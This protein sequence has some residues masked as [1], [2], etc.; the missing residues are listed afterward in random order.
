[1]AIPRMWGRSSRVWMPD[2]TFRNLSRLAAV[3]VLLFG[4]CAACDPPPLPWPGDGPAPS[5]WNA[6]VAVAY[7]DLPL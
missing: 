3:A 2:L 1:M 7:E 5:W 4:L 6:A